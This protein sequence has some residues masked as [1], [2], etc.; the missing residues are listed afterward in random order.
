MRMSWK[1]LTI[2]AAFGVVVIVITLWACSN[3]LLRP[4]TD[5]RASLLKETPIG[6]SS[7]EVAKL[8][9]QKGWI[10][11]N[12]LGTSGFLKQEPG[13]QAQVIGATSLAGHLGQYH[14]RFRTDVTAF[15]GFD[16]NNRLI[17]I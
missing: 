3:S 2:V 15:W 1:R 14:L 16:T 8:L 7:A 4:E 5:I 17:D 12:Y 13:K 9:K 10:D 11:R 6:S